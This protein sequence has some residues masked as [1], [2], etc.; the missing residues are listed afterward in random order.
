MVSLFT[1]LYV[2]ISVDQLF[3]A[4]M[5]PSKAIRSSDLGSWAPGIFE[6]PNIKF[7]LFIHLWA[8]G[9]GLWAMGSYSYPSIPNLRSLDN[10]LPYS[11]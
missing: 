10:H 2:I 9:Y 11:R 7:K 1:V 3:F 5:T 4:M 6:A 8:M